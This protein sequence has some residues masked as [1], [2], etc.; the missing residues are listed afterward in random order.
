MVEFTFS[1]YYPVEEHFLIPVESPLDVW[2][3]TFTMQV[4]ARLEKLG[5]DVSLRDLR[6]YKVTIFFLSQTVN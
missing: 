3:E 5:H 2:V 6:L 1:C 4:H